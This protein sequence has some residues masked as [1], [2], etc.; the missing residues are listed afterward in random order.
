MH[1]FSTMRRRV[2]A[3]L[4]LALLTLSGGL[5]APIATYA[6][7]QGTVVPSSQFKLFI[8]PKGQDLAF[9]E[10]GANGRLGIAGYGQ[11]NSLAPM[12]PSPFMRMASM[13]YVIAKDSRGKEIAIANIVAPKDS[14]GNRTAAIHI[15][16]WFSAGRTWYGVVWNG[17]PPTATYVYQFTPSTASSLGW[18]VRRFA[19]KSFFLQLLFK[20][21]NHLLVRSSAIGHAPMWYLSFTR[22]GLQ[23]HAI[24]QRW[25]KPGSIPNSVTVTLR[26]TVSP[27]GSVTLSGPSVIHVHVGQILIMRM[28]GDHSVPI[29]PLFYSDTSGDP[30][31]GGLTVR[32]ASPYTDA[33]MYRVVA[34]SHHGLA[35]MTPW[36]TNSVMNGRVR[37]TI[38]S[39]A[40]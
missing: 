14:F 25:P 7:T 19:P 36:D 16:M 20:A 35:A 22:T 4:A 28:V 29:T 31:D 34:T 8:P 10:D 17:Y 5:M 1:F 23:T 30:G 18:T 33:M 13:V 32:L 9:R 2:T 6:D 38:V 15:P 21:G 37:I 27:N 11:K 40:R 26:E 3:L 39:T 12:Y 24:T